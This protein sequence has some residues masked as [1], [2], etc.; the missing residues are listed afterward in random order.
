MDESNKFLLLEQEFKTY[1]EMT[2][3]QIEELK[4]VQEDHEKRIQQMEKSK[5]KTDYQ[6]EQIIDM[7][8]KLNEKTIPNLT[9]QIEELKDKPVKRYDQVITGIISAVVGGIV[10]FVINKFFR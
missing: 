6:Y 1:K 8:N 9:T 4:R 5:E 2:D 3:R 10:G 7:L